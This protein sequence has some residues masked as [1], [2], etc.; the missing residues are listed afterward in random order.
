MLR[1]L[2]PGFAAGSMRIC[3]GP[4][5][6]TSFAPALRSRDETPTRNQ[7]VDGSRSGF[8]SRSPLTVTSATVPKNSNSADSASAASSSKDFFAQTRSVSVSVWV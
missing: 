2:H 3:P 5:R 7:P 4:F 8:A 6:T 1:A